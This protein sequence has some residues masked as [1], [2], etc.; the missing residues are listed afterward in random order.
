[1]KTTHTLATWA[2]VTMLCRLS[3]WA[4]VVLRG[5]RASCLA[6]YT[7]RAKCPLFPAF[8]DVLCVRTRNAESF[9][10]NHIALFITYHHVSDVGDLRVP[11][12][13]NAY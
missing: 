5:V 3:D 2:A 13:S 7:Q 10:D 4:G 1:M 9:S 11:T 12:F 6:K 8:C